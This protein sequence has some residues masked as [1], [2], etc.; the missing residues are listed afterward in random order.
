MVYIVTP[1]NTEVSVGNVVE[2]KFIGTPEGED[3]DRQQSGFY[4]VKELCH[5]FDPER[6]VT[7]MTVVRDTFGEFTKE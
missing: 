3:Y 4:L 5:S 6:S 7:S 2:L 1:L